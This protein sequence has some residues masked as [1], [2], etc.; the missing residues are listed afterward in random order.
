M[1]EITAWIYFF[2]FSLAGMLVAGTIM[3]GLV[4]SMLIALTW[5]LLSSIIHVVTDLGLLE[6]FVFGIVAQFALLLLPSTRLSLRDALRRKLGS[7][8]DLASFAVLLLSITAFLSSAPPLAW[9]ARSIWLSKA[10]WLN[11][12]SSQ[13]L[14]AQSDNL[15]AHPE[16]PLAGPSAVATVWGLLNVQEDLYLGVGIISVAPLA[17][18]GSAIVIVVNS[19]P[20]IRD[21]TI[22]QSVMLIPAVA[23]FSVSSGLI[24]QGLM[25]IALAAAISGMTVILFFRRHLSPFRW[26]SAI[27][28]TIILANNLKQ[29]GSVFTLIVLV[30]FFAGVIFKRGQGPNEAKTFIPLLTVWALDRLIWQFFSVFANLRSSVSTDGIINNASELLVPGSSFY[31]YAATLLGDNKFSWLVLS[32]IAVSGL[33]LLGQVLCSKLSIALDQ[34]PHYS[35]L[36][37]MFAIIGILFFTYSLGG[38]RDSLE[39]WL[40]TSLERI[41]STPVMLMVTAMTLFVASVNS[42]VDSLTKDLDPALEPKQ[43]ISSRKES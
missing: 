13:Y 38:N 2:S 36:I 7:K 11:G 20:E 43:N 4:L 25:D 8:Q 3:G 37:S 10:T 26:A 17:I 27:A 16:Y 21:S 22:A 42:A 39:W 24:V 5:A 15:S 9:D 33:V 41:A 12:P 23:L 19:I 6:I 35:I 31:S 14:I 1:A 29:E 32:S 30:C 28:M 40:A 34:Y 18:M